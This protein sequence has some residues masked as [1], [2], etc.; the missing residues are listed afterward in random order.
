MFKRKVY[1]KLKNWKDNYA[2]KYAA[3]LEGARRVG[4]S[5]VAEEFARNN[6]K[7]Y[8][9]VDFANIT[10]ELLKVFDDIAN[11]EVFFLRLQAFTDITLYQGESVIIFDEI[12]LQPKV[13]QAIKYLV[14]DGRYDYIET[15]SLISIKKNVEN[16]VIPSEE[17]R[18]LV[19]PMD[20]EEFMWAIGND[21]YDRLR[22]FYKLGIEV[23]NGVNRKL[24]RDFRIYMAVGGMPQAVDSYINGDNFSMIDRIKR[25]IINLYIDD[26]K[27]IDSSG[28][29]GKMYESI[30]SQLAT[31]K[32]KYM[33]S[34][35]TGKRKT[36]K[37][38]QRLSDLI[39]SKT[40]LPCYN[41]QNPN[42]ALSQT[43]DEDT[44]KLYLSDIGL[45]T[46]MIFKASA[47]TS[48]NIYSKLLSDKLPADLGYLYEN[49]VAQIIAAT[50]TDLYYHTWKKDD[51]T[52]S[53]EVDFIVQK[54]TKIVPM[55]IKSSA[56]KKHESIDNFYKKYSKHV[57]EMY[58][59]S[60]KD[61]G[62]DDELKY[63]PLYMLPFVLEELIGRH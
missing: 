12:Q 53:Y 62:H 32:K 28:L 33:I 41:T 8:I 45:F 54:D 57:G 1:D 34:Q 15:G 24:M 46:T 27:K 51:S 61:V 38:K 11:L 49:A 48:E 13:R 58:L 7:S 52:H 9:K 21:T 10:N 26:F 63:K 2:P 37:D 14:A 25:D 43:K 5:T 40:V 42:V 18:I 20:Y 60:Q 55:E 17:H 6:Y 23:G 30:P 31:N 29:I 3:L 36:N 44:Y 19:Y 59:F 35:A 22:E 39:D 4:K 56:S 16:I 47:R 50:N